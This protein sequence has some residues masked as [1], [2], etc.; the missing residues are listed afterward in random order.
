MYYYEIVLYC[1][2]CLGIKGY[3]LQFNPVSFQLQWCN[4]IL[5][6]GGEEGDLKA[7]CNVLL[8]TVVNTL[9]MQTYGTV[10]HNIFE[11]TYIPAKIIRGG[12][13]VSTLHF[14]F[15]SFSLHSRILQFSIH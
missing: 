1:L 2:T 5:S 4:R 6:G 3:N 15:Q 10:L 12:G 7:A 11:G 14:T 13:H 8:K 9:L